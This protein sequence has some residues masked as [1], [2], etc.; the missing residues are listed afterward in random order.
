[1]R[2]KSCLLRINLLS[3][4]GDYAGSGPI[5]NAELERSGLLPS[6]LFAESRESQWNENMDLCV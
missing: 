3:G 1:M 4:M 2:V 6:S 5:L